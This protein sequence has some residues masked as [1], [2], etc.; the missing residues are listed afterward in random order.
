MSWIAFEECHG[1]VHLLGGTLD[2]STA[3]VIQKAKILA[4]I[5]YENYVVLPTFYLKLKVPDEH[6]R[7]FGEC[8][9]AVSDLNMIAYN[10][11]SLAGSSIPIEVMCEMTRRG[12]ITYCK[13]T[14]EDMSYFGRLVSE[15]GPLG[16]NVLI[17]SE[18]HAIEALLKGAQGFVPVS[19]NFE[20]STYTAAYEARNDPEK[21]K[22]I[23]E[24]ISSIVH[25]VLLQPRSWLSAAKYATSLR[26]FGSERPVSPTEP[27]NAAEK[28]QIDLFL[29]QSS[30]GTYRLG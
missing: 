12:W 27:L 25:N 16:L 20:P 11:P 2:T 26:G 15:A 1:R 14:S 29:A 24:R 13:D 30:I 23:H 6:M 3:R 17:G 4:A 10:L 7:L 22:Q 5:G 18:L 9:E 19:A 8:K 21:A 28:R